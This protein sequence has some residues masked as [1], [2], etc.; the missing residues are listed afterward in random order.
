VRTAHAL[1][2]DFKGVDVGCGLLTS[3]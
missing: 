3:P 1:H 2:F